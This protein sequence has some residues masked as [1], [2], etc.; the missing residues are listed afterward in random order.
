M[1]LSSFVKTGYELYI[2]WGLY[3]TRS[4]NHFRGRTW[5]Q[6]LNS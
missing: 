1:K 6:L 2:K 5:L 3:I 4:S